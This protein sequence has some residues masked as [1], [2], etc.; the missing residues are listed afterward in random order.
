MIVDFIF[1]LTRG[2]RTIEDCL[3]VM[4][5]IAP[6]GLGHIGFKDVGVDFATLQ[7]LTEAIRRA[8]AVSYMEVVSETPEACLRSA[9][10]AK[11]LGVDRLLGG[12]DVKRVRDILDGTQT[13]YY[14]FSGF[15]SGHPTRLG[16]QASDIEAHCT[17]F[18]TEGCGGTDLLAYRATAADPLD[19]VRAARR[20][21]GTAGRLIVAGSITS[22]ERIA[23]IAAAGADAFT[24]GTAVFDGSYSPR[25]G[26]ILSQL[27]EVMADC[28]AAA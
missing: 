11:R 20:G 24:I 12:T 7:K 19:L 27:A 5:E 22:R 10:V 9:E 17:R 18:M 8:G 1:M 26:S 25:K 4:R 28:A 14:P 13:Q 3:E 21:L 2:D 15:P 23:A 16:G 6:V